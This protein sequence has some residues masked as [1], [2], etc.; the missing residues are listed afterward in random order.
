MPSIVIF[1]HKFHTFIKQKSTYY[2][3]KVK[4][5]I[6]VH[7]NFTSEFDCGHGPITQ[8]EC[9]SENAAKN[10]KYCDNKALMQK[11]IAIY[12]V[13]SYRPVPILS[14]Y[15]ANSSTS[16]KLY[17]FFACHNCIYFWTWFSLQASYHAKHDKYKKH[18]K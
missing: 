15:T 14:Q 18:T 4:C 17:P 1:G 9:V 10:S 16:E 11:Y 7:I 3:H 12:N 5:L 13:H 2:I 8:F 6:E